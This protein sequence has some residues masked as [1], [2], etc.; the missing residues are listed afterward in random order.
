VTHRYGG[1]IDGGLVACLACK[2]LL[3]AESWFSECPG[4]SEFSV[5]PPRTPTTEPDDR[6]IVGGDCLAAH[7]EPS[8]I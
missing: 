3:D 2:K 5:A 6:T 8:D 1:L 4:D 7:G